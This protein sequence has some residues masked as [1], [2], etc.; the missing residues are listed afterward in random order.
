MKQQIHRDNG[1]SRAE[2]G[3]CCG[4]HKHDLMEGGKM[5]L[6]EKSMQKLNEGNANFVSGTPSQKDFV[7]QRA[8]LV[9]GQAPHSIIVTCSDS[10]VPPEHIFDSGLGEIFIVRNAGN[11]PSTKYD[12][13]SIEYAAEHLHTPLLVI[14]GHSS[15]GAINAAC[16]GGH[17][18]GNIAAIVK[19]LTPAV[20]MAGKDPSKAVEINVRCIIENVMKKSKIV[21]DLVKKGE[22]KVVGAIYDIASGEVRFLDSA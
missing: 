21:R 18:E 17:A 10:R 22:F 6:W 2:G 1:C 12:L 3:P 9:S 8:A 13:G 11:N 14:L 7:A 16:S 20:E 4:K 19:E 15:C 5:A